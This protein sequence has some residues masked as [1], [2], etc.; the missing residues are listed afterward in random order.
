MVDLFVSVFIDHTAKV[1]LRIPA[2]GDWEW[3]EMWPI[4]RFKTWGSPPG[5]GGGGQ[6]VARGVAPG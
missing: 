4:R 3:V 2:R 1:S 5:G 6:R